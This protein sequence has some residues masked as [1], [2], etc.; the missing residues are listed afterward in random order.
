MSDD[1]GEARVGREP[2]GAGVFWA[3]GWLF[4]VGYAG[5]GLGE[6]ILAILV[7]PW[8]LGTALA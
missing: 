4:T 1:G 8:Y 6:A 7:W 2:A 3:A 5:L